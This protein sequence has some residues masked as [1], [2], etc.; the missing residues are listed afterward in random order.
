MQET[1]DQSKKTPISDEAVQNATGKVWEEWF[2]IL[3]SA[4]G[5]G[6]THKEIVA[7]LAEH[8]QVAS[9]WQQSVTNTYEQARGKR[10]KHQMPE[11]YQISRSPYFFRSL[12]RPLRSLG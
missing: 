9:W 5:E 4:G 8:H 11:G 2:A 1:T 6:M 10:G 7:F 3:D 12:A